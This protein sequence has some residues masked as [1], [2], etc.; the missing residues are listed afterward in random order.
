MKK[1]RSDINKR[2]K[3]RSD[4][5]HPYLSSQKRDIALSVP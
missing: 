4:R 2:D 5:A 3:I 1:N